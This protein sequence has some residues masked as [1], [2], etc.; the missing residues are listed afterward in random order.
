MSNYQLAQLNVAALKAPLDS[1]R[2]QG[3][4]RQ[5]RPHQCAGGSIAGL[6]LAPEGGRQRRHVAAADGRERHRQHV[7]V[8]RCGFAA[9]LR[10][11]DRARGDHAAPARMVHAHGRGLHGAVVGAREDTSRRS[12]KP[13]RSSMLLREHGATADAFTF[14]EAYS[15]PDG[16]H[17]GQCA[18]L[19]QG[20]LPGVKERWSRRSARSL[21]SCRRRSCNAVR[22]G[23]LL[24]T[25][26]LRVMRAVQEAGSVRSVSIPRG[27][28]AADC[29]CSH[30][31]E[32]P[33][34]RIACRRPCTCSSTSS[35]WRDRTDVRARRVRRH[36][37]RDANGL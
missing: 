32:V 20:Q 1:A 21:R 6:R 26:A 17:R 9:R 5:P 7:R 30:C 18:V 15:A 27:R 4:R 8:A 24:I 34:R 13:W 25:H 37:A 22:D 23:G 14:G 10:V 35:G 16:R 28:R 36:L 19:V 11:Q 31:G 33:S 12:R 2:A 3:F 29:W